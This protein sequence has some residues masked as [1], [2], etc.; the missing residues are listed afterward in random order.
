[1]LEVIMGIVKSISVKVPMGRNVCFSFQL[2]LL[3]SSWVARLFCSEKGL[4]VEV[5]L[6]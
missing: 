2:V 4:I 1:M 6:R 5:I 3:K